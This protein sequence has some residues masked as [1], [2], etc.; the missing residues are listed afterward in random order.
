M[1]EHRKFLLKDALPI[2]VACVTIAVFFIVG[3]II[4]DNIQTAFSDQFMNPIVQDPAGNVTV[5][6]YWK[7]GQHIIEFNLYY[8]ASTEE[9]TYFRI[10]RVDEYQL[11]MFITINDTRELYDVKYYGNV[12]D[13]VRVMGDDSYGYF[14]V[15]MDS[16]NGTK[17]NIWKHINSMEN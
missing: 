4:I 6:N 1:E 15:V 16:Q 3:I 13:S 12:E 8:T 2:M 5:F 10:Y 11:I 14:K 17:Q 7:D 9:P